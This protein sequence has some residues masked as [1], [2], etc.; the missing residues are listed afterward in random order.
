MEL[1]YTDRKDTEL[2]V[3]HRTVAADLMR[4]K[5]FRVKIQVRDAPC[6]ESGQSEARSEPED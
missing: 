5:S 2:P 3:D 6:A 1:F 4:A